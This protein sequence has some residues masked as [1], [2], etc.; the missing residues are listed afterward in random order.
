MKLRNLFSD[1]VTVTGSRSITDRE[2]IYNCLN[3]FCKSLDL[4]NVTLNCG[5]AKGV[6]LVAKDWAEELGIKVYPY[7]PDWNKFGKKAGMLRNIEMINNSE[8][9]VG[10][11]DGVSKGT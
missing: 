6:D 9:C 4:Q 5:M 1:R 7:F 3:E 11:W 2:F 8:Y 10:I